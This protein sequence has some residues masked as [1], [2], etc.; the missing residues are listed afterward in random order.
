MRRECGAKL[1]QPAMPRWQEVRESLSPPWE[2]SLRTARAHLR[3]GDQL[4]G[5]V[6]L[7]PPRRW[8]RVRSPRCY[9]QW[10]PRRC[11]EHGGHSEKCVVHTRVYWSH[12]VSLT[13][14]K[15]PKKQLL[16][17]FNRRGNSSSEKISSLTEDVQRMDVEA[18]LRPQDGLTCL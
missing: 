16:V 5:A 6:P 18:R 11:L 8:T 7:Q 13:P 2:S 12:L 10:L 14:H 17:L 3:R 9:R 1:L 15:K 4:V